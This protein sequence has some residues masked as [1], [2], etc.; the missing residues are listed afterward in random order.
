MVATLHIY[1][2]LHYY[3]SAPIRP[4]LVHTELKHLGS[5]T[6]SYN[7]IDTNAKKNLCS[8]CKLTIAMTNK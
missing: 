2:P 8:K 7:V 1:V 5:D 3:C 6:N 4:Q